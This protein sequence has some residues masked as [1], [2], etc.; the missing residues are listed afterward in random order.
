M[1]AARA[2]PTDP[3]AKSTPTVWVPRGMI[4]WLMVFSLLLGCGIASVNTYL[5]VYGTQRLGLGPTAAGTLVA[6]LG[7]AGVAGRVGWS[8]SAGRPGRAVWLPGSLAVGSV[9]AALLAVSSSARP[10]VWVAAAAAGVFAVAAGRQFPHAQQSA[11]SA[12]GFRSASVTCVTR[13]PP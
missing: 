7:V 6:V 12:A 2:L 11:P 8:K 3:P 13:R 1:W 4:A 10:L 9:A 5:A